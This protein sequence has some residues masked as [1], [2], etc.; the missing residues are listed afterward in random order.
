MNRKELWMA[1]EVRLRT[2]QRKLLAEIVES[3]MRNIL[4]SLRAPG[5]VLLS[6][7][8]IEYLREVVVADELMGEFTEP[9]CAPTE[10]GLRLEDLIDALGE[11]LGIG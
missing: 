2:P 9:E 11:A 6:E 1:I 8:D 5:P 3:R 7:D 10:R 4:Q